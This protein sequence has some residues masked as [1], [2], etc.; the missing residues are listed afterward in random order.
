MKRTICRNMSKHVHPLKAWTNVLIV[1][2]LLWLVGACSDDNPT[3]SNNRST[4]DAGRKYTS[5]FYNGETLDL[6]ENA[7]DKLK[8][9]F[10]GEVA[11][12][13]IYCQMAR[14]QLGRETGVINERVI[15]MEAL[16]VYE[17]AAHFENLSDPYAGLWALDSSHHIHLVEFRPLPPEAPSRFLD[18]ETK[19]SLRLP[20]DDEWLVLWGGRSI[21]DNY[22]ADTP[23]QRFAYDF[24]VI[25]NG[26]F[27]DGAGRRNED[28]Y[29]FGK[30]IVAP[31]DG[32]VVETEDSIHDNP[33]GEE[34]LTQEGFL[35]NYVVIDHENGEYSLLFH[36]QQGSMAVRPG[37]RVTA[38]QFLGLCG[39]SGASDMPHLHYHLQTTPEPLGLGAEGLPIQ[40]R[41][42]RANGKVVT[43]GEPVRGQQVQHLN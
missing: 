29:A 19:T 22:H 20:F 7:S 2:S 3:S 23:D 9:L 18:Y 36:F 11:N 15:Q 30:S 31:G 10:D 17:R 5:W 38:G 26:Y 35:G 37:E 6:W 34:N 32:I 41:S 1:V 21:Q 13:S 25:E 8:M 4:L 39:N 28:Y 40:F 16:E 42:Y 12:F 27:Y 33:P 43:R 14:L 24:I